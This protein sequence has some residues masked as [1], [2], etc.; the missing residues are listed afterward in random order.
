MTMNALNSILLITYGTISAIAPMAMIALMIYGGYKFLYS[1]NRD[2]QTISKKNFIKKIFLLLIVP[3]VQIGSIYALFATKYGVDPIIFT[4]ITGSTFFAFIYIIKDLI[5][6]KVL[7]L[8][9]STL[10]NLL[11]TCV[12]M[13]YCLNTFGS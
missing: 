9:I 5:E 12:A 2:I 4:I 7:V 11:A 8:I 6:N 1:N 10:V 13:D 3:L